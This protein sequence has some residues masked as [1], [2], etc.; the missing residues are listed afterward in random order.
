MSDI[1]DTLRR[2]IKEE[3][4]IAL[5]DMKPAN[6]EY[7]TTVEAAKLARVTTKT[8]RAWIAANLLAAEHA[9]RVWRVRRDQLEALMTTPKR[10]R[11]APAKPMT[12]RD[13]LAAR[14][15]RRAG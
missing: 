11:K 12:I 1:E 8:I 7:L 14:H 15:A 13:H 4:A 3:V 10:K 2:I 9:G 5:R 6:D